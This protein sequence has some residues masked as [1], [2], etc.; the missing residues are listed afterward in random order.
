MLRVEIPL[1]VAPVGMQP[2]AYVPKAYATLVTP[3]T[4]AAELEVERA[5]GW[6]VKLRWQASQPIRSL[7]GDPGR[8]V[9]ACAVL[10]G[11]TLDA[12]WIT[13][14]A[15]EHAVVGALW[16]ADRPLPVRIRAQGLGTVERTD[17]PEGWRVASAWANGL[18][19]VDFEFRSFPELDLTQRLGVA[20]WQG[21]QR[22]RAGLKS[23]SMAWS[24][25]DG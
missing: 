6:R 3:N 15:P 25:L 24:V 21:A 5:R 7:E 8:F 16:R 22:E 11:E 18:W 14:G 9:D 20:V 17:P 4:T 12:P 13:M 10:T 2:G 19:Q 1:M 23:V